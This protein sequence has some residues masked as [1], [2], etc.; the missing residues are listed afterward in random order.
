MSGIDS[1]SGQATEHKPE[2]TD[3]AGGKSEVCR[4]VQGTDLRSGFAELRARANAE[5]FEAL[6]RVAYWTRHK[7][8]DPHSVGAAIANSRWCAFFEVGKWL[9]ELS[10]CE[11]RKLG[12]S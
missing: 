5:Q 7:D 8:D 6:R 12:G 9:D 3:A 1:V 2:P 11:G 10:G 4:N